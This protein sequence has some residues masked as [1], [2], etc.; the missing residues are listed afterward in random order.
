MCFYSK[1]VFCTKSI[2][3][4]SK[5]FSWGP[6]KRCVYLEEHRLGSGTQNQDGFN[7]KKR[8]NYSIWC[9]GKD[10]KR[11][12]Q[13]LFFLV[14]FIVWVC[15]FLRIWKSQKC[16]SKNKNLGVYHKFCE[17]HQKSTNVGFCVK[18]CNNC[19]V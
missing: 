14:K 15:L 19:L 8:I 13:E 7:N 2:A 12:L 10:V 6:S 16:A 5:L 4:H 17:T 1:Y 11:N 18:F 3:S 9:V